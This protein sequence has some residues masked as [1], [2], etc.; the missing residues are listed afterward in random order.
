MRTFSRRHCLSALLPTLLLRPRAWAAPA[1]RPNILFL[2]IDTLRA[3][4]VGACGYN[5]ATTPNV[6][7]LAR[8]GV[9]FANFH[10]AA[11]WTMPSIMTMFTSLHPS[12]HGATSAAPA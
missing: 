10:A 5:K 3:D 6:D 7:R 2:M 4:H 8:E 9:R 11:P 1:T 12:V